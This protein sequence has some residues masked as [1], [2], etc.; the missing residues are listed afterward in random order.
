MGLAGFI[1]GLVFAL[2]RWR[3]GGIAG[4]IL[5]HALADITSVELMPSIDFGRFGRP[6]ITHPILL[7]LGYGLIMLLP[8]YLWKI[9]PWV[10]RR[11]TGKIQA[12]GG[13]L[14]PPLP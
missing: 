8:V 2:I 11:A 7:I 10:E 1:I 3:A 13:R 4:L 6:N 9:H 12:S 14:P 5:A